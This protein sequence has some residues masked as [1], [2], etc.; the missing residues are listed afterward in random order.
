MSKITKL[1]MQFSGENILIRTD[2]KIYIDWHRGQNAES[3]LLHHA[4]IERRECK[5]TIEHICAESVT[6]T[7][8][9]DRVYR[10]PNILM[11]SMRANRTELQMFG[12]IWFFF[13]FFCF[14]CFSTES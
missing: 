1:K 6:I 3:V 11:G 5:K 4:H 9:G 2:Y 13:F 8:R 7:I 12:S 10:K 14:S